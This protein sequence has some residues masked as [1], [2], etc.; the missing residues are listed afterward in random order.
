MR[1]ALRELLL[2][3][4]LML[5]SLLIY[6]PALELFFSTDDGL[7]LLRAE[8][9]EDWGGGTR[10]LV[11]VRLFFSACWRFFGENP[12][13]YHAI[14]LALHGFAAWLLGRVGRRLGLTGQ[15][16]LLASLLFV[17]S[18]VGFT[19][20]HWISGGQEVMLAVFG[21][22][23][24]LFWLRGGWVGG[25]LALLFAAAAILSKEPAALLLPALA[26]FSPLPDTRRR[27]VLLGGAALIMG[28]VLLTTSGAFT[29]RP[30]GDPYESAYG[31]NLLW[32]SLT[33]SAWLVRPWDFFPDRLPQYQPEMW[34]WGL[35]L[36][37]FLGGL[38][39][40]R[41]DWAPGI[42]RASLFALLLMLPVL[43]LL[44]HSYLY[45]L[46]LP[47]AP[48][49]LL[50]AAGCER[51]PAPAKRWILAL[52]IILLALTM[53]RGD[54]RRGD[55][56]S[57]IL[58]ADPI[59]RYGGILEDAVA[60]LRKVDPNL[61][62][63][64]IVLTPSVKKSGVDLA[65]GLRR[66][67]GSRRVRFLPIEKATYKGRVLPLFFPELKSFV[68]MP[69]LPEPDGPETVDWERSHLFLMSGVANFVYLG[70]G[71]RGRH[72]LSRYFFQRKDY[73]RARREI[74]VLL[75]RYPGD[76]DRLYDLG[77]IALA[78]GNRDVVARVWNDLSGLAEDG[79]SQ[80]AV[81][82]A[83][84]F[85]KAMEQAGIQFA[86]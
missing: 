17:A 51:L 22:L 24:A 46:Y 55:K 12:L 27:R 78:E 52:P 41:R 65:Q 42:W 2:L 48:L 45:Y 59:L 26:L 3:A 69:D 74:E 19:C 77:A 66:P 61:G 31:L 58:L 73:V 37:L 36:P 6:R 84:A 49:L 83:Q 57:E 4:F 15:G 82:A 64:I 44:R 34:A 67:E 32:N 81:N 16:A 56:L 33:Y 50:A 25:V 21:L 79:Q 86:D 14:I 68:I 30:H 39:L 20:L 29:H 11:S 9:L 35:V 38:A 54:A 76:P 23:A 18:P 70:G 80:S 7:F 43:P 28:A 40:R 75:A 5:L 47:M 85:A 63:H 10:R 60:G 53:W 62:G 13:P 72:T 8:G 71:E 1:P